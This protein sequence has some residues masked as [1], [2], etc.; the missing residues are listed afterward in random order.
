MT[1][2]AG[3][4]KV[5]MDFTPTPAPEDVESPVE[6]TILMPCLNEART[7]GSCVE[8]ARRFLDDN[9][10][11]GEVLIA[12]NGSDDGSPE[13]ARGHGARVVDVARRGYG[14]A[15]HA[16]TRAARG[17]Y[18]VMGDA[19]DSY[20]F[21]HLGPFL[22][23]LRGGANLVMGNRFSG[24]I[25]PGAMP[26][27]NHYIGNP[28]LSWMGRMFF[29]SKVRDFHCG[30]RAFSREAF[31]RM[32]L[33]TSGMEFASEM[34]IK[35]TLLGMRIDEVPTTLAKDGRDRAPHLCPWRDGWRHLRFMLL[36]SP[37]WLFLYPGLLLMAVGAV[38]SALLISG[39]LPISG[40]SSMDVHSLLFTASA[41]N[42]GFQLV[43]FAIFAR[44]LAAR[45][46]LVP[47]S[48]TF[49]RLFRYITLEVGVVLGGLLCIC[50][51]V[52]ALATALMWRSASYGPLDPS[53]VMRLAIPSA[54]CLMLGLQIVF[55][56][57]FLSMLGLRT[58]RVRET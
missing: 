46:G 12:D 48:A 57:F 28:V 14:A 23:A 27:K 54:L 22:D 24:G 4:I 37:R 6:L 52:G 19:D 34:V 13:I 38:F 44:V 17:K 3:K 56:S 18:I 2:T 36:Y 29:R 35:A 20:D 16:G 40:T 49:E 42:V 10:I 21:L 45:E 47:P 1:A 15:L 31:D 41:V 50:G 58:R 11:S 53:R 26:W 51:F 43:M 32:Q 8:K 25:A 7:I 55:S 5:R 30:L 39:P 33:V 9:G